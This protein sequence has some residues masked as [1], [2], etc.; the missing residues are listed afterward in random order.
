M[1][2]SANIPNELKALPQWVL[3]RLVWDDTKNKWTKPP[4]QPN[5]K[6]ASSTDKST[7]L[8]YEQACKACEQ[9]KFDG[10]G[11]SFSESDPYAGIDLDD[12][13]DKDTG[14]ILYQWAEN[15]I[16]QFGSYCEV[17]P[18]GTG[19]HILVRGIVNKGKRVYLNPDGT[20]Y[21]GKMVDKPSNL[22]A[23][24]MYSSGRYFTVTGDTLYGLIT[25]E[26]CQDTLNA[27][28]QQYEQIPEPTTYPKEGPVTSIIEKA[29][30]AKN[31]SVFSSLWRGDWQAYGSQ[32]EADLA[33]CNILAFWTN[34]DPQEIDSLFRQSGLYANDT[35]IKPGNTPKW[36]RDDYR[37]RTIEKAIASCHE[38]YQEKNRQEESQEFTAQEIILPSMTDSWNGLQL[39]KLHG[40]DMRFCYAWKRW[41]VWN[42]LC[43]EE[44]NAGL[45]VMKAQDTLWILIQA[46]K[47]KL[48]D[49]PESEMTDS[50]K[51]QNAITKAMI[52]WLHKSFSKGKLEAMLWTAQPYLSISTDD[53]D[54]DTMLLGTPGGTVDLRT[55]TLRE[56][57]REDYITKQTLVTPDKSMPTPVWDTFLK[58][59]SSYPDE[60]GEMQQDDEWIAYLYRVLGYCL[61]GSACEHAMIVPFGGGRNGKGTLF[62]GIQRLLNDYASS[63]PREVLYEHK[64]QA[65]TNSPDTARL[66]GMRMVISSEGGENEKLDTS[67]V[68]TLVSQDRQTAC[69][70]YGDP[71]DFIPTHK[72]IFYTNHLPRVDETDDGS[73]ARLKI[74]PFDN[75]ISEENKDQLLDE[76]IASE[77]PGILAKLIDACLIWQ[78]TGLGTCERVKK[79]T[80]RYRNSMDIL[81]EFL[82]THC[83]IDK[84]V[85]E[86]IASLYKTYETWC[87]DE[88][89][90]RPKSKVAF[91]R[92]LSER[93]HTIYKFEKGDIKQWTWRGIAL[94]STY[95]NYTPQEGGSTPDSS[96]KPNDQQTTNTNFTGKTGKTCT[97]SKEYLEK[98]DTKNLESL[99]ENIP[100]IPVLPVKSPPIVDIPPSNPTVYGYCSSCHTNQ[101]FPIPKDTHVARAWKCPNCEKQV[102]FHSAM[103]VG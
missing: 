20:R 19:V 14:K 31:G 53:L 74:L 93:L 34:K 2:I 94:R 33:L 57:R 44:D 25:I 18:S 17:S 91:N 102:D 39:V 58:W 1:A 80:A 76:K 16:A 100:V 60:K 40:R 12:V 35:R 73:W 98:E 62:N 8:S 23:I 61:T 82:E 46:E 36:D 79:A 27:F 29:L 45:A 24:E 21:T 66:V 70:K 72:I 85:E 41:L 83:I 64:K 32:S 56:A 37:I 90:L 5:G 38:T 26:N 28:Y 99:Q 75:Q 81:A 11:F 69:K 4:F 47:A 87:E 42:G 55:K 50:E 78:Q 103:K 67:T 22:P 71:F 65:N 6:K 3:Y 15:I 96:N 51:R 10:I 52:T 84:R 49:K 86:P 97:F 59:A 92:M 30:R 68:K 54:K 88:A 63:M 43:W 7:W 9:G 77:Y 48:I 89:G 101:S 95:P 13:R